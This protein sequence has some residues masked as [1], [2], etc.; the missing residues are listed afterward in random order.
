MPLPRF[1]KLPEK[2]REAILDAALE[3]FARSGYED[4]SFNRILAVVGMSKGAIYYYFE[5]KEDLYLTVLEGAAQRLASSVPP[6]R[7]APS[8]AAFWDQARTLYRAVLDLVRSD[9]RIV[10]LLQRSAADLGRLTQ[11]E[12]FAPL[13]ETSRTWIASVLTNG[14]RVRAVREDM[15]ADL[16]LALTTAVGQVLDAH[17]IGSGALAT[18]DGCERAVDVGLDVLRRLLEPAGGRE[19][20][21]AIVDGGGLPGVGIDSAG[22]PS[23]QAPPTP[24]QHGGASGERRR[25]RPNRRRGP[26][27][28]D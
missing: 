10:R 23:G 4:A 19:T 15:P 18:S 16:L 20:E 3:E 7:L 11:S 26:S 25:A 14:Q 1:S 2:R 17:M 9:P 8:A 21:R 6:P 12:R 13:M 27:R 22:R 28:S 5:D 24:R